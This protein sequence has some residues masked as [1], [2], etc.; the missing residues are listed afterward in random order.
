MVVD[1]LEVTVGFVIYLLTKVLICLRPHLRKVSWEER[2]KRLL[3]FHLLEC[4]FLP[5][6]QIVPSN[7][8]IYE[9]YCTIK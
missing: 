8:H 1:A 3:V 5:M 9:N 7:S 6:V 2:G 4:S